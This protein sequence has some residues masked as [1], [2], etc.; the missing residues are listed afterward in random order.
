MRRKEREISD[1]TFIEEVIRAADVCT[2]AFAD[3]NIPYIVT[4]N[5]GYLGGEKPR[6]YFHCAPEGRKIDMMKKNNNVCF[7]MDTDHRLTRGE[8]G[9][10][11]GMKYK[12]VV[13]YGLLSVVEN[14]G[15]RKRGLNLI[16]HHYG[17]AGK[18]DYDPKVF[19]RTIILRLEITEIAAKQA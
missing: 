9:C 3:N 6:L 10:D 8:K 11:W 15:E 5:F 14:E 1:I 16:M 13:G 12:S 7:Q 17:G 2:I 18:Y 4:M 19:S